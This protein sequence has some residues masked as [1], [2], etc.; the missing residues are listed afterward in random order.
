MSKARQFRCVTCGRKMPLQMYICCPDCNRRNCYRCLWKA[1]PCGNCGH[2]QPPSYSKRTALK[3][4]REWKNKS[5][6]DVLNTL[7]TRQDGEVTLVH[8]LGFYLF[9]SHEH[10]PE[11]VEQML[12]RIRMSYKAHCRL[13]KKQR[14]HIGELEKK[15]FGK[16]RKKKEA[17]K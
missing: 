5:Y 9:I 4:V 13:A 10:D 8:E 17:V 7:F 14:E 12:R 2:K 1:K 16:K 6:F 15:L 11:Y 3:W